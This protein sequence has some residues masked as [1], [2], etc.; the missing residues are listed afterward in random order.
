MNRLGK[1]F[2]KYRSY[3]PIP[4]LVLMLVFFNG[5][6]PSMIIG[7]LLVAVGEII[8]IWGISY[9]GEKSRIT[10]SIIVDELV[11]EGPYAYVRNPLYVG[12][13]IIYFGFAVFSFALFPYLLIITML[14]FSFQYRMIAIVEE[15]HL[16]NQF[17]NLYAKYKNGVPRFIPR[18]S[19]FNLEQKKRITPFLDVALKSE[20]RTFQ[21]IITV[22]VISII[23]Y[24]A[25]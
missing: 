12:N 7:A 18:F 13:I 4:F 22:A 19:P 20:R 23:I 17:G 16:M 9:V 6:I 3:T 14:W 24:V 8:R 15:E 10:K 11:I 2:F 21:A 1:L 5:T 25:N